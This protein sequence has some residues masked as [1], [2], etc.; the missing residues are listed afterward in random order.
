MN[1]SQC[2]NCR[3]L[4]PASPPPGWLLVLTTEAEQDTLGLA[5]LF[6][7]PQ[8]KAMFCGWKCAAEYAYLRAVTGEIDAQGGQP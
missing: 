4:D 7:A 3:R 8:I 6:P 2:D 1:V 5:G